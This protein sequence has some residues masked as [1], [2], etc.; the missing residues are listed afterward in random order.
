MAN[1]AVLES[2]ADPDYQTEL[3]Q[4]NIELNV[5]P[6]P[7]PGD[8]ALELEEALRRSLNEAEHKANAAGAHIVMIGILPTIMQQHFHTEWMSANPRYSALNE[9][10][11][12]ARG[13]DLLIDIA[14][15]TSPDR[16]TAFADTIAP[17]SACTSVQAAPAGQPAGVPGEPGTPRRR[18]SARR[19]AV[20]ANSPYLF[21]KH[22]WAETRTVLFLQ[23][24]DTRS[25]EPAQP[26]RAAAGVLRR[27]V[28]HLDL[29]PV[30]GERALLPGAA[31]GGE[32]RGPGR[33]AGRR[34]APRMQEPRLHN[35]T[36]Y[37][38]N[39]P[40]YDIVD[41]RP[42]LRV[43]NRVLPA[44]PTVADVM[45]NSAF[46][47]GALRVLS[48]EDRPVWTKMSL[49]HGRV[50]LHRVRAPGHVG[51]RVLAGLRRACRPRSLVLR[52]LLPLAHE[53]LERWNVS[54]QV[55]E[56]YLGI[57]EARCKSGRN[58]A[59]WQVSTVRAL[60]ARGHHR[61]SAVREML[62]LYAG[63]MHSNEPVHTWEVPG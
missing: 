32:R 1:A 57:I 61:L 56:R 42:H 19:L 53:G 13:E 40:V 44:G 5:S 35:G 9:S 43:E 51:H 25:V 17:E 8:S 16:V 50:E 59:E 41:G 39:R 38:W 60:E 58:G 14:S 27:A 33:R 24:T 21:G 3:G 54:K 55:R 26:G 20:G 30:R 46:Y 47:Y 36:V 28:D 10:V 18:C 4:Y 52:H 49:R 34:G 11:F 2:I 45:A 31:A 63:N 6:R 7:L 23:A 22:L 37:R 62:R 29:R 48:E 15:P 12:A